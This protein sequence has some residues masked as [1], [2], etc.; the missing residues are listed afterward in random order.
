MQG[1]D[2]IYEVTNDAPRDWTK[3]MAGYTMSNN[4]ETR[5]GGNFRVPE[6][7]V[8]GMTVKAIIITPVS[9]NIQQQ[10]DAN[11]GAAGENYNNHSVTYG[12]SA[13]ALTADQL[14]ETASMSLTNAATGD[15]VSLMY[16][17][18]GGHASDTLGASAWFL[19][20]LVEYTA[21]S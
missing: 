2:A 13:D 8:S 3:N 11:H 16:T 21:D 9:G 15:N 4:V 12:P 1:T 20:W 17:R 6:D 19:G 18:D 14:A 7:F 10:N 5:I